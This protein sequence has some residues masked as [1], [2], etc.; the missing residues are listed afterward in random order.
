[1]D[2]PFSYNTYFTNDDDDDD[3]RQTIDAT[4]I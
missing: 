1:L 4:I 3:R 2:A